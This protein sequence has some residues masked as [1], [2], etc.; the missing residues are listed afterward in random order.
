MGDSFDDA[1]KNLNERMSDLENKVNE[2]KMNF[3]GPQMEPPEEPDSDDD[4]NPLAKLVA[5]W[6]RD[7]R[8]KQITRLNKMMTKTDTQYMQP[9]KKY[10]AVKA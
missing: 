2:M 8:D 9:F 7:S 3:G 1:K 6:D 4:E 5:S 10:E